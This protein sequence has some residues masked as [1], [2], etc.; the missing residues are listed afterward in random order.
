M[1]TSS[2]GRAFEFLNPLKVVNP[3]QSSGAASVDRRS[4]GIAASPLAR[5]IIGGM[6][7][8]LMMT[9]FLVP[10]ALIAVYGRRDA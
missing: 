10:A 5:A 9:V 7:A 1:A 6:T 8:S 4:S 2:P 3:A